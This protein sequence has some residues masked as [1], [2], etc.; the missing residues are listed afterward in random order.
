[1]I[2]YLLFD[3]DNTLYSNRYGLEAEVSRRIWEYT[4]A[5]LGVT[6]KEAKR[7]RMAMLHKYGTCLEW[8]MEEKGF[9]DC[10]AYLAYVHPKG[11]AD[12]LPPDDCLRAFLVGI[13]IPKAI[14]TNS[15]REHVDLILGKLGIGDLFTNIFDI[16]Q[17]GYK[18]KPRRDVYTHVLDVLG[19][20]VDEVLFIDDHPLYVNGFIAIGGR[21]LLIDEDDFHKDSPL[22]RIRDLRELAQYI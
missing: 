4:S 20:N 13:D 5:F 1:M 2:K 16:R 15:P 14:L 9:T 10:E 7:E 3:L 18:G 11:E 19:L 21:A 6:P 17:C 12:T 22:P 8:L